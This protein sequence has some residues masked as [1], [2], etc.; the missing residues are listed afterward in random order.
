MHFVIG[1]AY[2]GKRKWVEAELKTAGIAEH[3]IQIRTLPKENMSPEKQAVIWLGIENW[4]E[5]ELAAGKKEQAVLDRWKAEVEL[6]DQWE[7]NDSERQV[8]IIGCD[9]SKGIVPLDR[10]K[11]LSRD[12]AGWCHQYTANQASQVTRIW[13]GIA[14]RIKKEE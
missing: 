8:F 7:Q 5:H 14:E 1:G 11:R 12:V 10:T 13:Y 4:I 6:L 2:N 9:Q 3:A